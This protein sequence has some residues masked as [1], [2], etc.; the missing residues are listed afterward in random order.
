[1]SL[2]E[3]LASPS[4]DRKPRH[5]PTV[6]AIR[7]GNLVLDVIPYNAANDPQAHLFLPWFWKRLKDDGVISLYFPGDADCSFGPF[8][9]LF[10]DTSVHKLLFVTADAPLRRDG[11]FVEGEFK[12]TVKDAVGFA[13]WAPMNLGGKLVGNAGFI[14]LR[15]Y[16][17]RHTTVLATRRGMKF[18]F[19]EMTPRLDM[20]I[21]MNPLGNILVQRFL[22]RIG[23]TRMGTIPIPQYYASAYSD[24]ALWYITREQFESQAQTQKEQAQ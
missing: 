6:E 12:P 22:P 20:A 10:N 13:T 3:Q 14:F 2:L 24:M 15:D 9:A 8:V 21:G 23:W 1:M 17:D 11:A 4:P 7:E 5:S 18:W 16:W 19:E